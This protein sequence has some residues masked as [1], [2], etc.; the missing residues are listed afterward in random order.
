[1]T[2]LNIWDQPAMAGDPLPNGKIHKISNTSSTL[3]DRDR[4][5]KQRIRERERRAAIRSERPQ[6]LYELNKE[7]LS[8][9]CANPKCKYHRNGFLAIE[10][11]TKLYPEFKEL[12]EVEQFEYIIRLFEWNHI[13][14]EKKTNNISNIVR[15]WYRVNDPVKKQKLYDTMKLEL[16][17][18]EQLCVVCHRLET[19]LYGH[20]MW[21]RSS[22]STYEQMLKE[23]YGD[24]PYYCENKLQEWCKLNDKIVG[25]YDEKQDLIK[26]FNVNH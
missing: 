19:H 13:D 16:D 1:M 4:Y 9:G 6:R 10:D 26:L 3:S 22:Y 2:T 11:A 7:W 8:L 24:E 17:N 20:Y 14:R 18:C 23:K 21:R 5:I 25:K 15:E 12:P